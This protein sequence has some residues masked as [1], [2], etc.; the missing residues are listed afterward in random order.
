MW[1]TV[2]RA[3]WPTDHR[4]L[5]APPDAK[6]L[7]YQTL[8]EAALTPANALPWVPRGGFDGIPWWLVPA[9]K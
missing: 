7:S 9:F 5:F 4:G 1:R 2:V 8:S 6:P 3:A